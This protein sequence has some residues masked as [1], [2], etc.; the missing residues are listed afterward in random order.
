VFA[1]IAVIPPLLQLGIT[2]GIV[3]QAWTV[4][5]GVKAALPPI[6]E[7]STETDVVAW[8]WAIFFSVIALIYAASTK[9]A[10]SETSEPEDVSDQ[11]AA[12][13]EPEVRAVTEVSAASEPA[14]EGGGSL[15]AVRNVPEALAWFKKG[16]ELYASG[17]CDEAISG[18]DRALKLDPRHAGAWAGKGLACNAL[19]QYQEAVRCYDESLRLD[20]RDPAVWHDK[21][22]TLCAIGRVEGALNCFNE[23]LVI[24][25][26]DARAWNNKGICLASLGR[27]E[28]ALPCCIKATQLAPSYAVAW[29]AKA[30]IEERLVRIQDAVASYKRFVAVAGI[31]GAASV[32]R[33]QRH[34]RELESAQAAL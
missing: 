11:A 29:Q 18:F 7:S 31:Q 2:V 32:E 6:L 23:A 10:A 1:I 9:P 22:N 33:I 16:S 17:R 14:G 15:P 28:Q 21:G 20:P 13:P 5:F 8:A 34:V 25:P 26:R 19:R 24:D 30:M 12:E 3:E 4:C 27:P